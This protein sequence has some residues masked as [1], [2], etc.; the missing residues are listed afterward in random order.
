MKPRATELKVSPFTIP[1]HG[2][3]PVCIL[4]QFNCGII[5]SAAW[6]TNM[7]NMKVFHYFYSNFEIFYLFFFE[8]G[9]KKH[10]NINADPFR[11]ICSKKIIFN[12]KILA[13]I[14]NFS[15]IFLLYSF[16]ISKEKKYGF[17]YVA[18]NYKILFR[19]E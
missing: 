8:F 9:L 4:V 13:K 11:S 12:V 5:E 15:K 7:R 3:L 2:F 6:S 1:A 18:K 14:L 17:T 16:N 10:F 19:K